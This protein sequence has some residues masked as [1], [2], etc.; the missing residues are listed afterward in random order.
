VNRVVVSLGLLGLAGLAAWAVL[1]AS[2]HSAPAA[3]G[4]AAVV[5]ALE[6]IERKQD[7]LAQRVA[8]IE[9]HREPGTVAPG[10]GV[11]GLPAAM[12]APRAADGMQHLDPAHEAMRTTEQRRLLEDRLVR[13]P[14]SPAW[15]AA[16]EKAIAAFLAPA[17]LARQQLPAPRSVDTRCQSH[18]CRVA[19]RF[20]DEAQ[21]GQTQVMLL[22]EIAPDL[23]HAQSFLDPQPDGSVELVIFAGD[24][25]HL[26]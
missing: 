8:R 4:D 21:A 11:P 9:A 5:A 23:P 24:P 19:M 20:A 14:L 26:Q 25:A 12:A 10:R 17:S 18:L 3:G 2:N 13:D 7:E 22:M 1:H 16:H 15:S 6:R